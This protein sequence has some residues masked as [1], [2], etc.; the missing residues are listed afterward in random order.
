[1]KV[2]RKVFARKEVLNTFV[3]SPGFDYLANTELCN[4]PDLD[5]DWCS[6]YNDSDIDDLTDV[7]GSIQ[8][9]GPMSQFCFHCSN[10]EHACSDN[11]GYV[12]NDPCEA[13]TQ[14]KPAKLYI[15]WAHFEDVK[16]GVRRWSIGSGIGDRSLVRYASGRS[17]H[18]YRWAFDHF[19]CYGNFIIKRQ[20]LCD[21]C[22]RYALVR[23]CHY[24]QYFCC[25]CG[26]TYRLCAFK[27]YDEHQTCPS[28]TCKCHQ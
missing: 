14:K 1:M 28:G 23:T 11:C 9:I 2:L 17:L 21:A 8:S 4:F 15:V 10:P 5:L 24:R 6:V 12:F 25:R 19:T 18:M 13:C 20:I 16:P 22:V 3:R 27:E 7:V 26:E